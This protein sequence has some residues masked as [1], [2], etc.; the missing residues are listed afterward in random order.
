MA[1]SRKRPAAG[2]ESDPSAKK[3]SVSSGL[4]Q[5]EKPDISDE[6]EMVKFQNKQLGIRVNE[7]RSNIADL[8]GSLRKAQQARNEGDA[9]IAVTNRYW[10]RLDEDLQMELLKISGDEGTVLNSRHL[11][12]SE[13]VA[14]PFLSLLTGETVVQTDFTLDD[15]EGIGEQVASTLTRRVE[16]TRDWVRRIVESILAQNARCDELNSQVRELS[17][18]LSNN[19]SSDAAE[20]VDD[21]LREENER[22]QSE[23]ASLRSLNSELEAYRNK[24]TT[25]T[26]GLRDKLLASVN[27]VA[28][29]TNTVEDVNYALEGSR[30]QVEKFKVHIQEAEARRQQ[31]AAAASAAAKSED[32]SAADAKIKAEDS[33]KDALPPMDDEMRIEFEWAKE[34]AEE[35]LKEIMQLREEK[36][37]ISYE[38]DRYREAAQQLP[39]EK[40]TESGPYRAMQM[41]YARA[42]KELDETRRDIQVLED[43]FYRLRNSRHQERADTMNRHRNE[44]KD[45]EDKLRSQVAMCRDL[46]YER[47]TA[48]RQLSLAEKDGKG[49]TA[50]AKE[51]EQI[52]TRLR[53]RAHQLQAENER[54]RERMTNGTN[55]GESA[56]GQEGQHVNGKGD[57]EVQK[58]LEQVTEAKEDLEY[59]LKAYQS[60]IDA[61]LNVDK[62]Q[63]EAVL[64][65]EKKYELENEKLSKRIEQL[66]SLQKE[67]TGGD[68]KLARLQSEIQRLTKEG[69]EQTELVKVYE[70]EISAI[71][72][73]YEEA[74]EQVLRQNK[75]NRELEESHMK[76]ATDKTQIQ[77][78][79]QTLE[80][81]IESEREF[82]RRLQ[83]HADMMAN[84]IKKLEARVESLTG[85][86]QNAE[87]ENELNRSIVDEYK[88]RA[89]D[90]AQKASEFQIAHDRYK[91][92]AT[93]SKALLQSKTRAAEDA[94]SEV[95]RSKED[96]RLVKTKLEKYKSG[97]ADPDADLTDM[98]KMY[99]D[100][101]NCS[102]CNTRKKNAV[103]T[104]CFHCFC[105]DCIQTRYE[106]RNRKCPSCAEP[107]GAN[108]YHQIYM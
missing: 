70:S 71:G 40:I 64:K 100:Y 35:R 58:Q 44:M 3:R 49:P 43:N 34:T 65:S 103:I 46:T 21:A 91:K 52:I 16:K 60:A 18:Q 61:N 104:K 55:A 22:L 69:E 37:A 14:A 98:L 26:A 25:E 75:Q 48:R 84:E 106:M 102:I 74:Q 2:T 53:T 17:A 5:E 19:S 107:F 95:K 82:G 42:K 78:Q 77:Q 8:E 105:F 87:K 101:I 10:D 88:Q 63:L 31:L 27:K 7:L 50:T 72:E 92:E 90:E 96:L 38:R 83:G 59:L 4:P 89:H 12:K 97:T 76:L 56:A 29:L 45:L 66:E 57:S 24:G 33:G 11:A 36:R 15:K 13:G 20:K 99:K 23:I 80:V 41:Y 9:V 30:R 67:L 51:T 73:H 94:L 47:D 62:A 79:V 6:K 85:Q 1:D 108:D 39:D 68:D 54:L 28:T 81:A 93:D 32:A 86:L